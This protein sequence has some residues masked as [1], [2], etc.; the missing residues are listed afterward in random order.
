MFKKIIK[1]KKI[2]KRQK[3]NQKKPNKI[4]Y[5]H[6]GINPDSMYTILLILVSIARI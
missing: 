5:V 4:V 2:V 6:I 3:K 1:Y